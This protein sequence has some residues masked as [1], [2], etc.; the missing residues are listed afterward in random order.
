MSKRIKLFEENNMTKLEE[1]MNEFIEDIEADNIVIQ[2]IKY[3]HFIYTTYH[4]D[5]ERS[6]DAW[7]TGMI[8]YSD[9]GVVVPEEG[10]LTSLPLDDEDKMVLKVFGDKESI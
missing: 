1:K 6:S 8:V 9:D 10:G 2:D 3:N 4:P 7:Y 5:G